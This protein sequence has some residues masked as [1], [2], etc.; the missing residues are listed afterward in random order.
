[1][2]NYDSPVMQF[3]TR[4]A[5][6]MLLNILWIVCS[7][8]IV[9]LGV[10]TSAYYYCMLKIVRDTDAGIVR[11]FFHSFKDNLK[12]GTI[13]TVI[14]IVVATFL[15]VDFWACSRLD[16]Q[17]FTVIRLLLCAICGVLVVT[18]VYIFPV[19]AQFDN[20]I[21]N[22][23]KNAFFMGVSNIVTTIVLIVITAIP[24]VFALLMPYY[25]LLSLPIWLFGGVSVVV[26]VKTRFFVKVFDKYINE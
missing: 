20:T 10:S 24:I 21:K 16:G 5:D 22:T 13:L 15:G 3:L 26:Y 1:L 25:F 17:V 7:L 12:Q 11:M 18:A 6:F 2:F 14:L 4:L 9:T 19:L 8:P 23:V